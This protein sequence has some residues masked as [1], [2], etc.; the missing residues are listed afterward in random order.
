MKKKI[1]NTRSFMF[2]L[3]IAA[4]FLTHND[5]YEQNINRKRLNICPKIYNRKKWSAPIAYYSNHDA[6]YKLLISG[7]IELNPGPNSGNRVGNQGN[8]NVK[9]PKGNIYYKTVRTNSKRLMCEHCELLVN[10]NCAIVNLKIENSQIARLWSCHAC[11]LREL[12]LYHQD[13]LRTKKKEA[14][15][16]NYINTHVT[17]LQEL[18]THISICHLNTQ[19]MTSTFD[20][21]QFMVNES[22]FDII[23]LSETWLNNDKHL[24]EYVNLP[25]YKF[26]YRN[27]DGK[28]GRGVGVYIKLYYIQNQK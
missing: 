23:T 16:D 13:V 2:L 7:D 5:V 8:A 27:R 19:S 26:F 24:L 25:G 21:F 4:F 15:V 28:R 20:E 3:L 17:K 11:T 9:A 22:K 10:L 12:P 18:K 1:W 14:A 6:S